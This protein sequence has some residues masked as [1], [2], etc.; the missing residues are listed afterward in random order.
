MADY[1]IY[2]YLFQ[3][4]APQELL[5]RD[6]N[7]ELVKLSAQQHL[8]RLLIGP[9]V[10][11][12][13]KVEK[14]G[15]LTPLS[16]RIESKHDEIIFLRLCSRKNVTIWKD[17]EK[18]KEVNEPF[19]NIIIDNRPG[20]AQLAIEK[21]GAFGTN[22]PDKV[23][24]IITA[25][26]NKALEP[27]GY[28]IVITRKMRT[29]EVWDMVA[30]RVKMGDPVKSVK[31]DF[32]D[33]RKTEAIDA[34]DKQMQQMTMLLSLAKSM[35]AVSSI[36][37][38]NASQNGSLILDRTQKD[39]AGM[40]SLCTNNGWDIEIRF[41]NFGV[42]RTNTKQGAVF[43]MPTGALST[44]VNGEIQITPEHLQGE[45]SLI[46]WLDHVRSITKEYDNEE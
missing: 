44:F 28:E 16:N 20:I 4:V 30:E 43:S 6:D 11:G 10:L 2:K 24:D 7:G 3:K 45:F 33:P 13:N 34:T 9:S 35:G 41:K 5:F 32:H 19:C 14:D 31:F 8:D 26:V 29:I 25:F 40:V 39:I 23:V 42:Y 17:Y 36:Y 12:F 18:K 37:Q 22:G 38:M 1:V 46:E 21:C 15:S 27:F